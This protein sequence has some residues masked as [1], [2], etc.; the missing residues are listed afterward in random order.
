MTAQPLRLRFT[1]L[2][3]VLA[4]ILASF[5]LFMF[6]Q[7]MNKAKQ[8]ELYLSRNLVAEHLSNAAGTQAIERGVGNTIIGGNSDLVDLFRK[9]ASEGDSDV[10]KAMKIIDRLREQG[11]SSIDFENKVINWQQS[12]DAVRQNR[13]LVEDGT[14][15]S[16]G[17]LSIATTNIM[18]EFD[19]RDLAFTP[20]DQPEAILYYNTML[21]PDI[22]TLAE[23]AGLER[24]LIGNTLASG[25]DITA[26]KILSLE[27][28]RS[29]V[30][31]AIRKVK[32]VKSYAATSPRLSAAIDKF[33]RIFLGSYE[34]LRDNIYRIS[35]QKSRELEDG[36]RQLLKLRGEIKRSFS[37]P[38]R[39]LNSLVGNVH[40]KK[41]VANLINSEAPDFARVRNIFEDLNE[42]HHEYNQVRYIDASGQERVRVDLIDGRYSFVPEEHLQDKG[43]RYY[44]LESKDLPQ[45]QAYIS[46]LDLN[47]EKGQIERPFK[48][49][50]RFAAPVYVGAQ[51]HG[52]VVLNFFAGLFLSDLPDDVA[53][54]DENGFYLH[55][56]DPKKEWGMMPSLGRATFNIKHEFPK[57]GGKLL[58]GEPGKF[59]KGDMIYLTEPIH[60][61]SAG[62]DKFWMIIKKVPVPSYPLNS[63]DWINRATEAIDTSLAISTVVGELAA[64]VVQEREK[65]VTTTI[66]TSVALA[67]VIVLILVIIGFYFIS[68]G[69]RMNLVTTGLDHLAEGDISKRIDL[70][71]DGWTDAAHAK[72]KDEIDTIA[73][74]INQMADKLE[75][76][77]ASLREIRRNLE[78][79]VAE[80]TSEYQ[81]S[82]EEA[83]AANNAKS[84]F[85][86]SMSHELRTPMNA[87][88]GFT[89][90]L[91]LNHEEPLT[92][93][94]KEA[95]HQILKGGEHL[96][97]L[98]D[99]VLNL[100]KIESGKIDLLIEPIETQEAV[101]ECISIVSS[102]AQTQ[103]VTM[104]TIEFTG[105][106]ILADNIRFKQALLNLM[107]NAV[108]YN[109]KGGTVSVRSTIVNEGMQRISVVDTGYGIPA[110]KQAELFLP[111]SRLGAEN[112]AIEGTG[113]GLTITQRLLETMNGN[114]GFEST[115]GMGSIFWVEL[116][117]AK[118]Q[119]IVLSGTGPEGSEDNDASRGTGM[120]LYIEDNPANIIL[121]ETILDDVPGIRLET[122]HTA[123]L[124]LAVALEKKPDL[125]LMDINLPGMN[126]IEALAELRRNIETRDIPVIA[127]SAD[128]MPQ[129]IENGRKAGF[130]DYLTKPFNVTELINKVSDVL[131]NGD[132]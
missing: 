111:F 2:V 98:I 103:D 59:I 120:V 40:L 71:G 70:H 78:L 11:Y 125:I 127:I 95:T 15:H 121:M 29:R 3:L 33:E 105:S 28:F 122:T 132:K 102:L 30:D 66:T 85:L 100:A 39:E 74:R 4:G 20:V 79:K 113:I 34:D 129:D 87:I 13:K 92:E 44:V 93:K 8:N 19:L 63:S 65:A 49:M 131:S 7:S 61:T 96:L 51:R 21:R 116:P 124:G 75:D 68:V 18:N 123:E 1:V 115:E 31:H 22:S 86:S 69:R 35:A 107:S 97:N 128:A 91:E 76:S 50:L 41:Q 126:G 43:S 104:N 117:L 56:P 52:I 83:E 53:L 64:D 24:A 10:Q 108:K 16:K 84:D 23:F 81:Q 5:S 14:I 119:Q 46:P 67:I 27:R 62:Q 82:K 60:F 32:L 101:D 94:Q 12:F 110:N 80:R 26:D 38:V 112:S 25:G 89:Q 106:V 6:L 37:P 88:L 45:G 77:I 99:E 9:L 55:H 90:V 36:Q 73:I 58:S 114:I 17:W 47:V 57:I 109:R 72:Q 48:P 130:L 118:G 42:V 54:V